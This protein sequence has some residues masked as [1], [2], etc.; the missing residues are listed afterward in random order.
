MGCFYHYC[1]C[2]EARPSLTEKDNERG[3]KKREMD[4]MRKQYIEEKGYVVVEMWE[5]GWWNLYKTTTCVKEHLRESFPYKRPLGE[6]KLLEQIRSGKLFGSV[7]CDIE[8]TEEFKKNFANFQP[9]F[10]NTNV[11]RHDIGLL[12]NDYAEKEGLLCQPRKMLSSSHFLENGTLI[13]PLLLFYLDLGL[14]CKKKYRFVEYISV[15][16][17]NKFVQSAANASQEG[18]EN[19]NSSVVAETRR[20]LSNS[21]YGY[22]IMDRSRRTV[23]KYLSD[24]KTPG[25]INTKLFKRLDHMND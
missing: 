16:C 23:T 17:F 15:K 3:K 22:R 13:T 8:G 11:G 4:Q 2:Q 19:P 18:D 9:I 12:M 20:L 6:E 24:E 1:P 14:V 7:Q 21:S 10:K 25:A 5:C